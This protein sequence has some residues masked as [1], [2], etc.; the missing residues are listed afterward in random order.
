VS[1]HKNQ[2]DAAKAA[3]NSQEKYILKQRNVLKSK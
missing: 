2:Y 1:Q 3:D